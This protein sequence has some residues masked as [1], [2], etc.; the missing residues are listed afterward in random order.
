MTAPLKTVEADTAAVMPEIGRRARD[1]RARAG[2]RADRAEGQG[3]RRHRRRPIR[4]RKA[5]ILA[6]NAEDIAEAKRGGANVGLPRPARA[7]RQARRRHGRRR[8]R[9]PRARRSGRRGHRALDA[10]ERHDDR[11]R[12]RAARRRSASSTRAARTSPPT[13]PRS[14]SRPAMPRSCAA[15]PRA[16]A[17]TAPSMPRSRDGLAQAGLAGRRDPA[18]ADARPRRGRHDARRPR[19]RR[20]T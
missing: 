10:A 1:G 6:A 3:A 20:S 8:R 7:R 17:P 15:A 5:E 14:A 18:G 11:A 12:A 2:A 19:R 9:G 16:S 13:P 4:A